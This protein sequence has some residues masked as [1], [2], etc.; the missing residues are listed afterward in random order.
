M[1]VLNLS[2]D[3]S[4]ADGLA[5]LNVFFAS[6]SYMIGFA[7]S[8]ADVA[9][10]GA[11]GKAPDANKYANLARYYKH[12]ASFSDAERA[13]F[14]DS[15]SAVTLGGEAPKG[16]APKKAAAAK[17]AAPAPAADDDDDDDLFGSD[18]DDEAAL[19]AAKAKAKAAPKKKKPAKVA[20]TQV[21][22]EVKP[23]ELETDLDE[24][25]KLIRGIQQDGLEWGQEMRRVPV[26]FG[27]K[28]LVLQAVIED[29]KVML[30]DIMGP[31]EGLEDHVQ[32]VELCTMNRL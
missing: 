32:S 16:A 15:I 23:L 9:L 12:I 10:F 14:P 28:K 5:A 13:A 29:D 24:L 17:K 21:V 1:S 6:R 26:A 7:P 8:Q 27:I 3:L 25:E 30:D 4:K 20:K 31:I 19:A 18:S 22:L 11:F 2:F